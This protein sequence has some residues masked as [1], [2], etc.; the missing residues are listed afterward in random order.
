M[1]GYSDS[2][3]KFHAKNSCCGIKSKGLQGDQGE[4]G[5]TG[6]RGPAGFQGA[7]GPQGAQGPQGNCCVGRTGPTGAAGPAGGAQ[8]P[9]GPAGTGTIVNF[10]IGSVST[11]VPNL[12][13]SS[14][15]YNSD[16]TTITLT[17]NKKWAISWSIQ[18]D[19]AISDSDFYLLLV[20]STNP[21]NFYE[22]VVFNSG[23]HFY[24]NA[25]AGVTCGTGNDVINLLST[26]QPTFFIQLR[27]GGGTPIIGTA[28]NLFFS[29]SLTQL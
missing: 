24:L 5:N 10:N 21:A 7:T 11:T 20:D 6:P 15:L 1:S 2:Y 8:G 13:A 12:I 3:I 25:G 23:N 27:Q 22:P 4:N 29:I 14:I 19:V 28:V 26:A 17:P 18:E 9:T 16:P